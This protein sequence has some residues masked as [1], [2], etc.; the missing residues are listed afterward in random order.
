[1]DLL[2][3]LPERPNTANSNDDDSDEKRR[4]GVVAEL[5]AKAT[6]ETRAHGTTLTLKVFNAVVDSIERVREFIDASAEL[7]QL[8][9]GS[10]LVE[11]GFNSRHAVVELV[12]LH[13]ESYYKLVAR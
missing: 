7:M 2:A 9:G 4:H 13:I 12:Y 1:M 5:V 11:L 6:K 8:V 3:V 10:G